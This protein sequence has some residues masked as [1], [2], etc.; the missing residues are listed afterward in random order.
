M[1]SVVASLLTGLMFVFGCSGTPPP[2]PLRSAPPA[3]TRPTAAAATAS[4]PPASPKDCAKSATIEECTSACNHGALAS[5]VRVGEIR[6]QADP[7][8][9]ATVLEKAC[10]GGEQ[11]GCERLAQLYLGGA[12]ERDYPRAAALYTKACDAG[13]Q[14]ACGRLADLRFRSEP[15]I[16]AQTDEEFSAAIKLLERACDA[17]DPKS[18]GTLGAIHFTAI[19]VPEDQAKGSALLARGCAMGNEWSCGHAAEMWAR[20]DLPALGDIKEHERWARVNEFAKRQVALRKAACE[21][22][23]RFCNLVAKE[24]ITN[25]RS[26]LGELC[27]TRNNIAACNDL[28]LMYDEGEQGDRDYVAAA[29]LFEIACRGGAEPSCFELARFY[30][31]GYGVTKDPRKTFVLTE[32]SCALGYTPAC[33]ILG[34]L[35]LNGEGT[36]RDIQKSLDFRRRACGWHDRNA[37][38]TLGVWLISHDGEEVREG[39]G[40]REGAERLREACNGDSSPSCLDYALLHDKGWGVPRDPKKARETAQLACDRGDREACGWLKNPALHTPKWVKEREQR[41]AKRKARGAAT[42]EP[43]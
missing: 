7:K 22:T 24:H 3:V 25:A 15:G 32:R 34:T 9:A 5:C 33:D 13:Y 31:F 42:E 2:R 16:E 1:R 11:S 38:R 21:D 43:R 37:C 29:A 35:Y 39:E 12:L 41:L 30:K 40:M 36:G 26:V 23:G 8:E 4:A 27:R 19:H 20:A 14:P 18:C 6:T 10:N 17:D 28:G